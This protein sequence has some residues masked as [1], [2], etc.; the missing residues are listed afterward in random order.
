MGA[1]F[2]QT[3]SACLSHLASHAQLIE[4]N[5]RL[6]AFREGAPL[7]YWA[8]EEAKLFF[9]AYGR[10]NSPKGVLW[11]KV[12]AQECTCHAMTIPVLKC[13]ARCTWGQGIH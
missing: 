12:C 7:S 10:Y 3:Y 5:F 1:L 4:D 11:D 8:P 6:Q 9:N 13:G 2:K